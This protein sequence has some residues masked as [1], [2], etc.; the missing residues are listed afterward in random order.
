MLIDVTPVRGQR[1]LVNSDHIA[2][3]EVAPDVGDR[4]SVW[5][6]LSSGTQLLQVYGQLDDFIPAPRGRTN[7]RRV[8]HTRPAVP[9]GDGITRAR[10]GY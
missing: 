7:R 3:V 10:M 8:D 9:P 2:R 6:H 1:F 5:L 4:P